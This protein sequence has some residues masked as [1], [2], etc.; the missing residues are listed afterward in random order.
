MLMQLSTA[1]KGGV[2]DYDDGA[3]FPRTLVID[4]GWVPKIGRLQAYYESS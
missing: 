3:E 4:I 1:R 2:V